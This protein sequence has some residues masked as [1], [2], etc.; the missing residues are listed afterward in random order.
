[1]NGDNKHPN[2]PPI[3]TSNRYAQIKQEITAPKEKA[4]PN[5]KDLFT[6]TITAASKEGEPMDEQ[7]FLIDLV[8]KP[9]ELGL[10]LRPEETQLLLAYI[11][12]IL[13]EI[14]EEESSPSL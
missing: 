10:K 14:E 4:E 5:Q 9:I 2:Q 1:V 8:F 11:G 3:R 7:Q 12:E 13:K 6:V